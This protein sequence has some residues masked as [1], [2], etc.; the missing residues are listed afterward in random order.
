MSITDWPEA[1]RPREKL[2]LQGADA[3]SD[4]E[5]LA[6][7]LRVGC[8]GK[9]AVDLA[10][11]LL[12]NFGGLRP[13]L[14]STQEEFCRGLGLGKAK[15]AQLQAVM[16]MSRRH[17]SAS[18]Q[19]GDVMSSPDKVR[20]FLRAKLRHHLREV[21][22]VI[23]LDTQNQFVAYEEIFFGTLDAASIY[24]REIITRV[25]HYKS[26]AVIF[27]HNHPSGIAEPSQADQRITRRLQSALELI[28][29]RVL[30]HMIVGNHEVMS[31]AEQGLL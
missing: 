9:S 22:A 30:D 29:V 16:E 27:A 3:L 26:A 28:D 6:I 25:L 19:T 23:F 14:E 1:E 21:F 12:A 5:L 17:L 10:R 2:L 7:F 18:L 24:P 11:E 31:F 15:Y 13:L 8:A 20:D 4:A